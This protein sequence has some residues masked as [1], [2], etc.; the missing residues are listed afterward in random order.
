MSEYLIQGPQSGRVMKIIETYIT[1]DQSFIDD[2]ILKNYPLFLKPEIT[3]LILSRKYLE[4]AS[5]VLSQMTKPGDFARDN[6]Y[7]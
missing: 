7:R 6:E 2:Q 4:R 1:Y 5:Q 3:E